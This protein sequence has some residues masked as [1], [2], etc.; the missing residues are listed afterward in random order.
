MLM[1]VSKRFSPTEEFG[2][3]QESEPDGNKAI[4]FGLVIPPT[5]KTKTNEGKCE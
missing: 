4:P 2:C 3:H 1:H 5:G